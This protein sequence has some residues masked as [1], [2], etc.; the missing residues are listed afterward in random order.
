MAEFVRKFLRPAFRSLSALLLGTLLCTSCGGGGS[1]D[2]RFA[3]NITLVGLPDST[4]TRTHYEGWAVINGEAITTGKFRVLGTG[5]T[6]QIRTFP[7]N[8]LVGTAA[9]SRFGP[10]VT[11]LGEDFPLIES[12]EAFFITLEPEGDLNRVPSCQVMLAG[13]L[14]GDSS[15]LSAEGVEVAD[16]VTCAVP[17]QGGMAQLGF[18]DFTSASGTFQLRSPTDDPSNPADNDFAGAWFVKAAAMGGGIEA[19]L[20]LPVL[21]AGLRYEGWAVVDGETRS[22]GRFSQ[23]AGPDEDAML[24]PQRGNDPGLMFPGG[25]FVQALSPEFMFEPPMLQLSADNFDV[26][27][28]FRCFIGIEPSPDTDASPFGIEVLEARIAP[29]L[30]AADGQSSQLTTLTRVLPAVPVVRATIAV[31][32]SNLEL[33]DVALPALVF[34]AVFTESR[35]H[36]ALWANNAGSPVLLRR[37]V[38]VSGQLISVDDF[39]LL[40]TIGSATISSVH[41]DATPFDLSTAESAFITLE[42]EGDRDLIPADR[43]LVG[44]ALGTGMVVMVVEGAGTGNS[45]LLVNTSTM[46]GEFQLETPSNDAAGVP[47]DDGQGLL[48]GTNGGITLLNLPTLPSGWRYE[49]FVEELMTGRVFSTGAFANPLA[50]DDN[51]GISLSRGPELKPGVPGEDFLNDV[52]APMFPAAISGSITRV[53]VTIEPVP[54]SSRLPSSFVVFDAIVPA[55]AEVGGIGKVDVPMMSMTPGAGMSGSL[56]IRVVN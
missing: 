10:S 50:A 35:G 3:F 22:L 45:P 47:D 53:F 42:T 29:N 4:G 51:D 6:A 56:T 16:T 40:G 21:A 48:F 27:G 1:D 19:G 41:P 52:P 8:V 12:A 9:D 26:N 14:L 32:G 33:S 2:G 31:S 15:T 18:G 46:T 25:D 39:A 11:L 24:A 54:A 13:L 23:A 43:T 5:P 38:V 44:G 36:Y 37:F 55:S 34:D 30:V 20:E 28:D 17:T 49:G 7:L